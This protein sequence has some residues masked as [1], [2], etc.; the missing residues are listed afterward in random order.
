MPFYQVPSL[1]HPIYQEWKFWRHEN[2]RAWT[3]KGRRAQESIERIAQHAYPDYPCIV[4]HM[5]MMDDTEEMEK[6]AALAG[7]EGQRDE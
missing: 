2:A 4:G 3:D 7:Q 6:E 5:I 1:E